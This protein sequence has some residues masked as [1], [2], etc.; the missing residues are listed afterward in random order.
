[1]KKV[2][3]IIICIVL[4]FILYTFIVAIYKAN[5]NVDGALPSK[6]LSKKKSNFEKTRVTTDNLT[7]ENGITID[8]SI[9]TD[10]TNT[11]DCGDS[12]ND[13]LEKKRVEIYLIQNTSKL[14]PKKSVYDNSF[15]SL[16]SY[17]VDTRA[18]SGIAIYNDGNYTYTKDFNYTLDV[19]GNISN[20][21]FR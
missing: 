6:N 19:N 11:T 13:S 14:F 7:I 8:T 3:I 10:T 5:F 1:M 20:M 18:N 15:W 16:R 12:C 9:N 17:T 4:G 21:I 2:I